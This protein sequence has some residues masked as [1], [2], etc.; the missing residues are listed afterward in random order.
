MVK[1]PLRVQPVLGEF[2]DK[3]SRIN[4][5]KP[6]AVEHDVKLTEIGMVSEE[7]LHLLDIY[8]QE[9]MGPG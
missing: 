9:A 3:E 6:Y 4:F 7:H 5:G 2:L 8:F 1:Q